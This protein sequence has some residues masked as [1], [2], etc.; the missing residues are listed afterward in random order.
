MIR[1]SLHGHAFGVGFKAGADAT[2]VVAQMTL[3]AD[4]W[5]RIRTIPVVVRQHAEILVL[6]R[7]VRNG[8]FVMLR[9]RAAVWIAI[10][11]V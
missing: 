2:L 10:S 11:N 6:I 7:L 4:F 3:T 9:D 1:R 8:I 5:F